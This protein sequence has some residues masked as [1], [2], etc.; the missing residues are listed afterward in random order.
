MPSRTARQTF[1]EICREIFFRQSLPPL[2]I[3]RSDPAAPGGK[4]RIKV[5]SGP[6]VRG[7]GAR[8]QIEGEGE[9]SY[10]QIKA[11]KAPFPSRGSGHSGGQSEAR[12]LPSP[13]SAPLSTFQEQNWPGQ[14]AKLLL[15]ISGQKCLYINPYKKCP[16]AGLRQRDGVRKASCVFLGVV[17]GFVWNLPAAEGL[18]QDLSPAPISRCKSKDASP[19]SLAILRT[20]GLSAAGRPVRRLFSRLTGQPCRIAAASAHALCF[21]ASLLPRNAAGRHH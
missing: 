5:S 17:K 12:P 1:R 19:G 2:G 21:A 6:P 16:S 3:W 8:W 15:K 10:K 11:R 20:A 18:A 7:L 13:M 4:E 14:H 9:S